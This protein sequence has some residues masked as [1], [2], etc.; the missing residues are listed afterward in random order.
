LW[1]KGAPVGHLRVSGNNNQIQ[2]HLDSNDYGFLFNA[3]SRDVIVG[4]QL[5][6]SWSESVNQI[7]VTLTLRCS[8]IVPTS[9]KE[10]SVLS[11]LI[12]SCPMF[13]ALEVVRRLAQS[14]IRITES[15]GHRFWM[16]LVGSQPVC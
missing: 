9:S 8:P 12:D 14:L 13:F 3:T 6:I 10:V 7:T 15:P 2:L 16:G 5:Q 11:Q 1:F 4:K